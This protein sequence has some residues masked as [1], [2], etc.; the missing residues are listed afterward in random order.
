MNKGNVSLDFSYKSLRHIA[1]M[2]V[3]TVNTVLTRSLKPGG[4]FNGFTAT[5]SK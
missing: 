1:L 3:N 5:C 2:R 4:S